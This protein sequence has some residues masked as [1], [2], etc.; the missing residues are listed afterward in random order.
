MSPGRLRS[1]RACAGISAPR[2]RSTL[3]RCETLRG[4]KISA[5]SS[6]YV[7]SIFTRSCETAYW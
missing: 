4:F 1:A 3:P 7:G 2:A 5:G 6:G